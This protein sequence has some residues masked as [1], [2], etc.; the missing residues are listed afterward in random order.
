M[1]NFYKFGIGKRQVFEVQV[2]ALYAGSVAALYSKWAL[3][4]IVLFKLFLPT[5]ISS[6]G[7]AANRGMG[8]AL[9]VVTSSFS[10]LP[11][12]CALK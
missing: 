7:R 12:I 2:I 10:I 4:I 1:Q 9:V 6:L 5:S 11:L 8:A 3:L